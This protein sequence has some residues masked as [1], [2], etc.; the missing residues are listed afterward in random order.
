MNY[1]KKYLKLIIEATAEDR[2][3]EKRG[4]ERKDEE[5]VYE[6]L[7]KYKDDHDVYISFRSIKKIGINPQSTY[8]TPNGIY[9]YPLSL[10]WQNYFDHRNNSIWVPFALDEPFIYVIK[11]K[12]GTKELDIGSY[13]DDDYERDIQKLKNSKLTAP[14]VDIINKYIDIK[15]DYG[16]FIWRIMY[17]IT[18]TIKD[19]ESG[20]KANFWNRILKTVLGYDYVLD[21]G[22]GVIHEGEPEQAVFLGTDTFDV[23]DVIE[24]KKDP[25]KKSDVRTG[26]NG[27]WK[28]DE[29]GFDWKEGIFKGKE[30]WGENWFKGIWAGITW[31][32]KH[33]WDGTWKS[34]TWTNGTWHKG[35]WKGGT[36]KD[37]IWKDGTWERGTWKGGTWER[38]KWENGT[39]ES[40]T[41][42]YGRWLGGEWKGGEWETGLDKN[43]KL[44][45]DPP[46]KWKKK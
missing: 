43:G 9:T 36:W 11:P 1:F 28:G 13:Q 19:G 34:G 21:T 2:Y 46:D 35:T 29:R 16:M 33:W 41:W 22:W 15:G 24:N 37:G 42:K 8:N 45:L 12:P 38:G 30:W 5:T 20:N 23:I 44:R 39:W 31:Y 6:R 40:G 7:K 4:L 18:K 27:I 17:Q 14:Y 32:G 3:R 10:I 25:L 26:V